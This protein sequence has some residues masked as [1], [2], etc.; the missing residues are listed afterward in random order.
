M[1]TQKRRDCS[2]TWRWR[3]RLMSRRGQVSPG[4]GKGKGQILPQN[5]REE[6]SSWSVHCTKVPPAWACS[7]SCHPPG[8]WELKEPCLDW[9][10]YLFQKH[11][12][13]DRDVC[14]WTLRGMWWSTALNWLWLDHRKK[15][16]QKRSGGV[17]KHPEQS[18]P[19][20]LPPCVTAK[21]MNNSRE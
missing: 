11:L 9:S 3:K 4:S 20:L 18:F 1:R 6:P 5:P 13:F 14:S 8:L 21:P 16:A 2:W 19:H 7:C 12:G 17:R 10:L 15:P